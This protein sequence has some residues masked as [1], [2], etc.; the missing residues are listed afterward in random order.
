MALKLKKKVFKIPNVDSDSWRGKRQALEMA[1]R[2]SRKSRLIFSK[3]PIKSGLKIRRQSSAACYYVYS[4]PVD[5][6]VHWVL[7]SALPESQ[8]ILDKSREL[9]GLSHRFQ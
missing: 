9:P 7:G 1:E 6:A 2:H 4:C 8:R 3:V 5:N